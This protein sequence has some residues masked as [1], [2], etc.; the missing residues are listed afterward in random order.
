MTQKPKE[1]PVTFD[2]YVEPLLQ[3][4]KLLKDVDFGLLIN[5]KKFETAIFNL[6]LARAYLQAAEAALRIYQQ[7]QEDLE[8]SNLT[9]SLKNIKEGIENAE[10]L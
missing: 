8:I 7:K 1:S 3:A 9:K 10:A 2:D 5:D 6:Q 4:R